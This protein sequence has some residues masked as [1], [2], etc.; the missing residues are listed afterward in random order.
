M[1]FIIVKGERRVVLTGR[2]GSAASAYGGG[3][4]D[5]FGATGRGARRGGEGTYGPRNRIGTAGGRRIETGGGGL[6][7]GSNGGRVTCSVARTACVGAAQGGE[8]VWREGR[9]VLCFA[10]GSGL[11]H[12][13]LHR[14]LCAR[15]IA[16]A[17]SAAAASREVCRR[18]RA[19]GPPRRPAPPPDARKE[20][21]AAA[22]VVSS[23]ETE[24]G[25]V[26]LTCGDH[27]RKPLQWVVCPV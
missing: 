27:C 21:P 8:T 18:G 4:A 16:A 6:I 7:G 15:S 26:R 25:A 24:M 13:S 23:G 1:P 20:E 9:S 2:L 19:R 22:A 14:R 17:R 10:S 12:R 11:L 5:G 3:T